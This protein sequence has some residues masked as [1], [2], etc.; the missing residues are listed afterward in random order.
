MVRAKHVEIRHVLLVSANT[1]EV[2]KGR[3]LIV[4][5]P[6]SLKAIMR[7]MKESQCKLIY[8]ALTKLTCSIRS[9]CI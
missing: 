6:Q 4:W 9:S 1:A 2:L 7:K 8:I 3:L 5:Q